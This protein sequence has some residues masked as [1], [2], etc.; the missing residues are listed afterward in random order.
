MNRLI[1]NQCSVIGHMGRFA[2]RPTPSTKIALPGRW[3]ARTAA[4]IC[5]LTM[6][7]PAIARAATI[8]V[9][10]SGCNQTS[11]AAAVA[12]ASSGDTIT[13]AAGTYPVSVEIGKNMTLTLQGAGAGK[14]ILDAGRQD[15]VLYVDAGATVNLQGA[16][17]QNAEGPGFGVFGYLTVSDS[18]ITGNAE[19]IINGGGVAKVV[20]STISDNLGVFGGLGAG[21]WNTSGETDLI[22]STVTANDGYVGG[23]VVQGGLVSLVNSTMSGNTGAIANLAVYPGAI[24][25]LVNSTVVDDATSNP[26][27]DLLS[28]SEVSMGNSILSAPAGVPNCSGIVSISVGHNLASDNSCGLT[29]PTDV[30]NNA[31]INL[32]PLQLNAPGTTATQAP[33]PGS[34][35]IDAGNCS[36]GTVV[37]DQRGVPRPQGAACDIGAY[38][39][40]TPIANNDAYAAVEGCTFVLSAPGVMA[41]DVSPDGLP[42]SV[43]SASSPA[44]GTISFVSNGALFYTPNPG[45]TGQ[46]SVIYTL[47]DGVHMSNTASVTFNVTSSNTPPVATAD[48][49]T[50]VEGQV[51]TVTA[52]QGMLA[53]DTDADGNSLT[54]ILKTGPA[55]G[56]LQNHLDGSFIYTP[57]PGFYGTDSFTYAAADGQSQSAPATVTITVKP[58]FGTITIALSTQP[59]SSSP[60]SFSSTLGKFTLGGSNPASM[61]FEVPAGTWSIKE[62]LPTPWLMSNI[63]CNAGA[64]VSVNLNQNSLQIA[65]TDGASYTCTFVDELPGQINA[66][67]FN[68]LN[69]DGQ[70]QLNEPYLRGW[71]MQLYLNPTVPVA[72][73]VVSY[74]G[75]ISFS[76]LQANVYTLCEVLP[77]GWHSTNS[78]AINPMYGKPCITV[79]LNPGQTLAASFGNA[80]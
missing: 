36:F 62:A 68:D 26:S 48:S 63:V 77:A 75:S 33:L 8:S 71:T 65:L 80:N 29:D 49:Y 70:R 38:E 1:R 60:F 6:T 52:A 51:L 59:Q 54:A 9:C 18:L 19:G 47:W 12:A 11:V 42:L 37:D 24:M 10:A 40:R 61:T 39:L 16:T 56:T 4:A 21:V 64:G 57:N 74:N 45:F 25:S 14:T 53:N 15:F 76:N 23:I 7:S 27:M 17:V 32:G 44:N 67:A 66:S 2:L 79:N 46:D 50:I 20:R 28:G 78:P 55:N 73:G 30:N 31:N 22:D 5:M 34:A 13:I 3:Q 58:N 35:A 41:N 69:G 43:Y 72:S